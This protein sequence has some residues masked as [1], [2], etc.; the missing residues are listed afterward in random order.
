MEWWQ[1]GESI[2]DQTQGILATLVAELAPCT[3]KVWQ[4]AKGG[5]HGVF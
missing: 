1:P 5:A 4:I 3:Q 2:K